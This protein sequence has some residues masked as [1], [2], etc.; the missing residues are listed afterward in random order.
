ML[1]NI[2]NDHDDGLTA[3]PRTSLY[4]LLDS[5]YDRL[6]FLLAGRKYIER[7]FGMR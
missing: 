3:G 6:S 1:D 7:S 5:I 2:I 4:F